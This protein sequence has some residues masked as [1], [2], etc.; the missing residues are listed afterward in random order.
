MLKGVH[1]ASGPM[2]LGRLCMWEM[3]TTLYIP[4]CA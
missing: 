4:G 1:I 2:G 3:A